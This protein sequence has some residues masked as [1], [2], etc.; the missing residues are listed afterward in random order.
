MSQNC[1]VQRVTE[2]NMTPHLCITYAVLCQDKNPELVRAFTIIY[3][4]I[5]NR[6]LPDITHQELLSIDRLIVRPA[7]LLQA[8]HL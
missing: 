5:R 6:T 4:T 2:L 3:S 1:T 8:S 7:M